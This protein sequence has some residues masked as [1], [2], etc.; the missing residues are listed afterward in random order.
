MSSA[1]QFNNTRD[2]EI[3]RDQ[4]DVFKILNG[5]EN[6]ERNISPS[7]TEYRRTSGHEVA[8]VK[9]QCRLNRRKS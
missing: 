4:L 2:Q 8:F 9:E 1:L 7:V 5:Y 6:I 3:G